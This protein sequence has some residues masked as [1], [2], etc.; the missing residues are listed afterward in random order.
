ML[1]PVDSKIHYL[2]LNA[3]RELDS[4]IFDLDG[5]IVDSAKYHYL[6]WQRLASTFGYSF[7]QSHNELLKG[8]SREESLNIILDLAGIKRSEEEKEKLRALKN[9]WYLEYISTITPNEI[10]PG[11]LEFIQSLRRNHFKVALGSASKNASR[12]LKVLQIENLFDVIT[13]GNMVKHAKPDPEVF[14][15]AA[16]KLDSLPQNCVVFED[17]PKGITAAKRAGMMAI[18]IGDGEALAEADYVVKDLKNMT[19]ER[20]KLLFDTF[21]AL[22]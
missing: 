10:L 1:F 19:L 12:I 17:A 3:Q 13:D 15:L 20:L 14:L 11:V 4:C 5:V 22:S 18:G 9:K 6:A 16:D 2:I 8:V 7:S 21:A